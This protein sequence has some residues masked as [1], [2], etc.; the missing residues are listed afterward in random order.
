MRSHNVSRSSAGHT[1]PRY[2]GTWVDSLIA[3]AQEMFC[4]ALL[5]DKI[6]FSILPF[7]F[8]PLTLA[9]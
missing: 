3:S 2:G 6:T 4:Y 8:C 5:G 9:F 1:R 7:H